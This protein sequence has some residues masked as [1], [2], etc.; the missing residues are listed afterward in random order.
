VERRLSERG[1]VVVC[2]QEKN[3]VMV[4]TDAQAAK[5]T[6]RRQRIA[7]Q[8]MARNYCKQTTV[9]RDALTDEERAAHD[10]RLEVNGRTLSAMRTARKPLALPSKRATPLPLPHA[11]ANPPD[12]EKT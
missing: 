10:R 9:D 12:P 7:R 2:K 1:L 11:N 6:D 5:Y 4:L 8:Q 3:D